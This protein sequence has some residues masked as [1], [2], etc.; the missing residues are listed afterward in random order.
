MK[1]IIPLMLPLLASPVLAGETRELDAHEHGVSSLNIAVEGS[2]I[3]MELHAPGADIVGFEHAAK[4]EE[5][6]A[7]VEAAVALLAQPLALF[8]MPQ[9]AACSVVKAAAALEGEEPHDDH[10][11]AHDEAKHDDHADHDHDA[12][13]HAGE[14][15]H[16]EF[17]AEYTLNCENPA[18][19]TQITFNFFERFE[20]AK[21]VDVQVITGSGAQAFEVE[22]AAPVLELNGMF[23]A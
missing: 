7:A 13:D 9:S 17:H 14:A 21:E 10:D 8:E 6:R 5:D 16:S 11:H 12:H 20:N 19:I 2:T 15:T 22:R 4:S 18:E 23:G 1:K 3:A